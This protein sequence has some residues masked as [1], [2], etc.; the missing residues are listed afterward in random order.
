MTAGIGL[1]S[2]SFEKA[3]SLA[4][5][6]KAIRSLLMATKSGIEFAFG[7]GAAGAATGFGLAEVKGAIAGGISGAVVGG[8]GGFQTG[9]H[10][11]RSILK[12]GGQQLRYLNN[13]GEIVLNR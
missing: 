11:V 12:A 4:R 13:S 9:I 10:E 6:G 7:F 3:Q 5:E 1:G 2:L 8:L